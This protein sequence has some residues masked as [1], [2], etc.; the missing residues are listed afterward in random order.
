M[1]LREKI[2][3][4]NDAKLM[5]VEVPEWNCTLHVRVMDVETRGRWEEL[6]D[7]KKTE[8]IRELLLC[9]TVCDEQ[10]ELVFTLD[11]VAAL[12]KKSAVA[13]E[14]L[15]VRSAKLNKLSKKDVR[16]LEGNSDAGQSEDSSSDSPATSEKA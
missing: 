15:F 8:G 2:L 10:G 7:G 14:R 1:N 16:D 5:P 13:V 3:S 12:S 6:S 9:L 4:L 11:D